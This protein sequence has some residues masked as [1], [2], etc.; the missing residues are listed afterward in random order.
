MGLL[1]SRLNPTFSSYF[2]SVLYT[3]WWGAQLLNNASLSMYSSLFE[4]K[5][6]T[7]LSISYHFILKEKLNFG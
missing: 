6:G 5:F 2:L 7:V 3:I 4:E 1:L